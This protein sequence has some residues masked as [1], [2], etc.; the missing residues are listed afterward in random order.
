MLDEI[1]RIVKQDKIHFFC[2]RCDK[3]VSK[4]LKAVFDLTSR[5]DKLEEDFKLNMSEVKGTIKDFVNTFMEEA[6]TGNEKTAKLEQSVEDMKKDIMKI[7]LEQ[8]SEL[9]K[10]NEEVKKVKKAHEE[11][12][13]EKQIEQITQA[14]VKDTQWSDIVKKEVENKIENVSAELS[15]IQ[16]M[17]D[18]TKDLAEEEKEKE[19]RSKNIIIYRLQEN[20]D[21]SFEAR[22]KLDK[23]LVTKIMKK[24]IDKDFEDTEIQKIF[25][26]GKM[27]NDKDKRRPI[28]V[29]FVDRMTKNYLMNNL[30]H[31]RKSQHKDIIISH[32]MTLKERGQCKE[33]VEEAKK[34][35]QEEQ[36]GEWIFRVRGPPGQMKVMKIRKRI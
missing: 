17:V 31:I 7:K 1:F 19:T 22:Q 24:L 25:R 35:E 33:L 9:I 30:Y 27:S 13:Y 2:G 15:S 26:L 32:D 29:Q 11:L 20:L 16:K 14:F 6:K 18:V 12:N 23:A 4:I 36:S 3:T 10:L 34:K 8:K 21:T 5:Q 28:L